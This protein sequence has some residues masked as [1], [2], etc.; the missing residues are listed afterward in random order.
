MKTSLH[1]EG[2]AID[3]TCDQ[4]PLEELAKLCWISGFDWVYY[5]AR[6]GKGP[7]IHCSVRR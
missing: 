2:R 1:K 3:V 7:H 6:K 4:M 5:E